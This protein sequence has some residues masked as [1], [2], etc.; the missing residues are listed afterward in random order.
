MTN[1]WSKAKGNT[2]YSYDNVGNI[3]FV[4]YPASTDVTLA[5]D[6]LNRLTN[7]VDAAGTTKYTY[8][9]AS[10]L[11]TEDGPWTSDTVTYTYGSSV[12]HLRTALGLQQPSGSWTNGLAYDAARRLQTLSGPMGSFTY[13]YQGPGNLWTN[14]ALPSNTADASDAGQIFGIQGFMRR[15]QFGLRLAW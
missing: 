10:D 14:L 8:T 6:A 3:T 12:P 9:S 4:N 5:Y 1:R 15:M 7:M 11:L 13:T 2:Y